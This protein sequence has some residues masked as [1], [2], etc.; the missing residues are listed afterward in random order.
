MFVDSRAWKL[1][2]IVAPLVAFLFALTSCGSDNTGDEAL[3]TFIDKGGK[4]VT[5]F[6][7]WAF[8]FSE[9][10]A[11]VQSGQK[12]GYINK[13]GDTKIAFQFDAAYP[14]SDGLA[15]VGVGPRFDQ[16][17]KTYIDK[18]GK[19]LFPP[20]FNH[21]GAFGDGL[22]AAQQPIERGGKWGFVDR[23]GQFVIPPKFD[24]AGMFSEGLCAVGFK[25]P[26]A[27]KTGYIDRTGKLVIP[28]RY[29]TYTN[30][31]NG[32]ALVSVFR[33]KG[34]SDLLQIDKH[35]NKI[36]DG[37]CTSDPCPEQVGGK[38]GYKNEK[39]ELVIAAQYKS[40]GK[41]FSEGLASVMFDNF[42]CGY[43]NTRGELV[44]PATFD[45]A[46]TF[47]D[48]LAAI[49][50]EDQRHWDPGREQYKRHYGFI[51]RTGKIVIPVKFQDAKDF[52]DGIALV[53]YW[54]VPRAGN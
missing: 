27:F 50:L 32:V 14:F 35:G 37:W 46:G 31:K 25:A 20:T 15:V 3:W 51:D 23:S 33:G 36:R 13:K 22:G 29:S 40:I 54:E 53:Q 17:K 5:P 12:W 45:G 49:S 19:V 16:L 7:H 28:A 21:L 42:K 6:F 47:S 52:R 34:Q 30:F 4:P 26:V 48:G 18:S 2:R 1:A 38:W 44:I 24:S 9:G 11:A 43:I 39:G 41:Q 8:E 10:L